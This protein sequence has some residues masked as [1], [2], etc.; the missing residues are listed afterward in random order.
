MELSD[1][2]K[3]ARTHWLAI[4]IFTLVGALLAW[5]VTIFSPQVY[6]ANATGMVRMSGSDSPAEESLGDTL[7]KSRAVTYVDVATGR[8]VAQRVIDDLNLN[9]SPDA[10][11]THVTVTQPVDTVS[12]KIRATAS[13]PGGA[14]ML[15]DSWVKAL[16]TQVDE[17]EASKNIRVIPVEA[18]ALPTRPVSPNPVRNLALGTFLGLLGGLGYG[19]VRSRMDRRIRDV[20]TVTQRFGATVAGA[21]PASPALARGAGERVPIVVAGPR[22]SG[23][24]QAAEAFF[25]VRTNLQFMDI[26]NPPRV[27]V[28]TSP[29]PGDGKSTISAN[30]AVALSEAGHSVILLDGD[31]R[32]PVVAE[33]FGLVEGVGLTDLLTGRAT[34]DDVS[35]YPTM[36]P[37][38]AVVGAGSIPPNPSELLGSNSMRQLLQSLKGEHMVIIDAPPL[39]P[40]TDAAVLTANA[41]G[42]LIVITAGKTLDTQLD[43]AMSH[44]EQVN[45][46][47]LGVIFNKVQTSGLGSGYGYYGYYAGYGYAGEEAGKKGSKRK[48]GGSSAAPVKQHAVRSDSSELAP[49]ESMST[50]VQRWAES[51]G[52]EEVRRPGAAAVGAVAAGV[53][54]ADRRYADADE[55][56]AEPAVGVESAGRVEPAV[57]VEPEPTYGVGMADAVGGELEANRAV[58]PGGEFEPL[59]ESEAA[60]GGFEVGG[61]PE[62]DGGVEIG[63]EPEADGVV[64]AGGKPE[65]DGGFEI[66]GEPE[67]DGVVE[68]EDPADAG[69]PAYPGA[70]D[71]S[72]HM[73]EPDSLRDFAPEE[74]AELAPP[75][76]HE[77]VEPPAYGLGNGSTAEPSNAPAPEQAPNPAAGSESGGGSVRRW[78]RR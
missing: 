5:L 15:A 28:V 16:A 40:V 2:L 36:S 60:D 34:L 12:L 26:D 71:G 18:A 32:R 45:G 38:L 70:H 31:L 37:R 27:I 29:L 47:I 56:V 49:L 78:L 41:D 33:S 55:S 24:G 23:R 17:I 39:L 44:L 7:A 48:R 10:L 57:G 50:S 14:Q 13:T 1:Y 75:A 46:H 3:I 68:A 9:T 11:I 76:A 54:G 25:K 8:A 61:E 58:E 6:A 59:G 66:G 73:T 74:L 35:Q 52:A 77:Q 53:L 22:E 62:A 65:T 42:A 64:E 69:E 21:I 51:G 63:G 20:D 43:A 72:V 19:V 30:L 4:L 67:A